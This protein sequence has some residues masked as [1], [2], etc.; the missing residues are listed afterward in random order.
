[1]V[2][3]AAVNAALLAGSLPA[4]GRLRRALKDPRAA[5]EAV[6]R[7]L[8]AA[9]AGTAFGR[10]H[11]LG[12]VRTLSEFSAAVPARG[13]DGLEP[14]VR[15]AMAGEP[16]V[17]TAEPVR[18]F[19][20]T[21][22][23]SG[24]AKYIPYTASLQG[25]FRRAVG[26]WLG[27]LALERPPVMAG[28][29][30]WTVTPL[31]RAPSRTSGGI[32]VGFASDAEVLGGWVGR[33]M[34]RRLAVPS[35]V[36]LA[37]DL[38]GALYATAR[39]LLQEPGLSFMSLW[40][41]SFLTLL[42]GRIASDAER[43]LTDLA[44]GT[45]RPPR[46]LCG[47]AAAALAPGLKAMPARARALSPL[48]ARRAWGEVWPR[49]AVVSCWADA[50]AASALPAVRAAFPGVAIQGKGLLATEGV[51]S[52]PVADFGGCVPALTSHLL[53]FRPWGSDG[54][55]LLA[56]ELEA[57][58]EYD[59]LMTTGGGL[60]RYE[61]G[62]V[63][64]VTRVVGRVPVLE[65]V[66]RGAAASDLRGEKLSAAFVGPVLERLRGLWQGPF[67]ML[68]PAEGEPPSYTLFIEGRAAAALPAALDAALR[69]NPHYDYC[70]RLGQLGPAS[71]FLVSGGAHEA[72][73]A[74]CREAGQRAGAVKPTPLDG[75]AGWRFS[76]RPLDVPEG[77]AA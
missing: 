60:W 72:Y 13:Y 31:A 16:G 70:R 49:L 1:M 24:A 9:N 43:L 52:V 40:N 64:R 7:R 23:S 27:E 56:D 21:S 47:P 29:S 34:E 73:L 75:R 12:K 65:F 46:P 38:D 37:G 19:E 35:A 76:G 25:E 55:A 32:P 5:Q 20:V 17:L 28:P 69:E 61:L 14:W 58:R 39:F 45:L 74:R 4:V 48:L 41:P 3:R 11:G 44:A 59:V 26:A 68:A 50:S 67:A 66:G 22:G 63:V 42:L 36:A 30:Y 6:L 71:V 57:G 10:E 77:A 54:R 2:R 53:E 51:V 8:L 33:L 15:R 62:D 18:L